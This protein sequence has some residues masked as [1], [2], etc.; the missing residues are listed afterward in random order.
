MFKRWV[1][2]RPF[3]FTMRFERFARA[4][5]EG[6]G[7]GLGLPIVREI[8]ERHGGKVSLIGVEPRGLR[9]RIDLPAAL[10]KHQAEVR[11][12]SWTT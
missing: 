9:G 1:F 6:D 8:V 12:I 3:E 2:K 10:G 5:H 11:T 4:T 7:A